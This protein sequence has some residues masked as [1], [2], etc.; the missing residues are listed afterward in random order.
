MSRGHCFVAHSF[1][2][3]TNNV[4]LANSA[5]RFKSD[6]LKKQK[7][8]P[9]PSHLVFFFISCNFIKNIDYSLVSNSRSHLVSFPVQKPIEIAK[10]F[11]QTRLA[12]PSLV[13]PAWQVKEH[14]EP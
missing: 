8:L 14:S 9:L 13:Y 10:S 11:S 7:K 5:G 1:A 12:E 6:V 3:S 2:L 4:R